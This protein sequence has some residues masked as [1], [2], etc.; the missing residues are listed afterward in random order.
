MF[1]HYALPREIENNHSFIMFTNS[2]II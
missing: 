2:Y 1:F